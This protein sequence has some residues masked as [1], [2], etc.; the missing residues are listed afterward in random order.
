VNVARSRCCRAVRRARHM[1]YDLIREKATP[2]VLN[3][4]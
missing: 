4:E 1:G 2:L 3:L